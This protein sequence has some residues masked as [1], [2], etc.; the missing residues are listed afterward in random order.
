MPLRRPVQLSTDLQRPVFPDAQLQTSLL[1]RNA[2]ILLN[3]FRVE[4]VA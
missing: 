1:D 3:A 4:R 2:M